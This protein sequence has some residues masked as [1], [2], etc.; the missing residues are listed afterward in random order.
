L[1]ALLKASKSCLCVC[2]GRSWGEMC[3]VTSE[4]TSTLTAAL[5]TTTC[6]HSPG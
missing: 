6:C 5:N 3:C 4:Q 2:V 1:K